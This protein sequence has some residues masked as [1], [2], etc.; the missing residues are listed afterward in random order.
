MR[1]ESGPGSEGISSRIG[2][3]DRIVGARGGSAR[4]NFT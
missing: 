2:G 3:C 1:T 4:G